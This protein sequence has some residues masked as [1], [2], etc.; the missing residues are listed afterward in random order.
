MSQQPRKPQLPNEGQ[1]QDSKPEETKNQQLCNKS[2]DAK[3]VY[4][5]RTRHVIYCILGLF[6]AVALIGPFIWSCAN[7]NTDVKESLSIWNGFVS[8]ALG[9][10]ATTLS[11]VSLAMN[12]KTYDDALHVQQQ[13]EKTLISIDAVKD[14]I[15]YMR[16]HS[17]TLDNVNRNTNKK[18]SYSNGDWQQENMQTDD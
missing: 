12:F 18:A 10:V 15:R 14:D 5:M 8:I 17:I 1:P 7:I 6:I 2:K 11:I 4:L 13:A 9:V 16:N 3:K